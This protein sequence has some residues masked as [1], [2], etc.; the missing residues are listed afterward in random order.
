MALLPCFVSCECD[1][2]ISGLILA[3]KHF[4]PVNIPPMIAHT[5]VRKCMKDLRDKNKET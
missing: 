2:V 5:P 4:L 3:I 1:V